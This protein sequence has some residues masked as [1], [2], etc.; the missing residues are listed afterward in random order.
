MKKSQVS[1]QF[2][3]IFI[4][5][6]GG[7]F[8]MMFFTMSSRQA[9]VSERRVSATALSGL[10]N[11]FQAART[12]TSLSTTITVP[13]MR[14]DFTCE[15]ISDTIYSDYSVDGFSSRIDELPTFTP[16]YLDGSNINTWTY[17][18]EMPYTVMNF[19]YL[20]NRATRIF[21]VFPEGEYENLRD[22]IN[23]TFS[24][25]KRHHFVEELDDV[26]DYG[27]DHTVVAKFTDDGI[28]DSAHSSD[29]SYDV[30]SISI[31]PYE[32]DNR[33]GKGQM[34]DKQG[35]EI[36]ETRTYAGL[37]SLYGLILSPDDEF[38]QCSMNKAVRRLARIS[39]IYYS[40]YHEIM[41][42]YS[43]DTACYYQYDNAIQQMDDFFGDDFCDLDDASLGDLSDHAT[44]IDKDAYHDFFYAMAEYNTGTRQYSCEM[45]Y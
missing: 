45:L 29:F 18:W 41:E 43:E 28:S 23:E 19:L 30:R 8:L 5:I 44:E 40:K 36:G 4:L 33:F 2:N 7:F 32:N 10:N 22:T 39:C 25:R 3:W 35:T 14:V 16:G 11:I 13:S 42:M 12:G 6:V 38:Y 27:D 34:F 1:S 20:S 31:E 26:E 37:A 24:S 9:D 15:M 21:F 17:R